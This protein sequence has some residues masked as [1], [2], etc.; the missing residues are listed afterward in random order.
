MQEKILLFTLH[1]K[2]LGSVLFCFALL[3]FVLFCFVLFCFAL[4][5][6]LCFA[7]FCFALL[8]FALLCFVCLLCLLCLFACLFFQFLKKLI[9]LRLHLFGQKY[10]KYCEILLHFKTTAF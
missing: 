2:S 10:S 7:L 4:L 6:L 3:C 5:A 1:L 9:L 8:C